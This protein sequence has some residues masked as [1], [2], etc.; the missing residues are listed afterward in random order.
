MLLPALIVFCFFAAGVQALSFFPMVQRQH[1]QHKKSQRWVWF[2]VSGE[3]GLS[4]LPY[5]ATPVSA[6]S[7]SQQMQAA[8]SDQF[9]NFFSL[10]SQSS[11]YKLSA[12]WLRA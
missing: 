7:P 4:L 9:V 3:Q 6:W 5:N 2:S 11:F 12:S 10:V 1:T 8:S